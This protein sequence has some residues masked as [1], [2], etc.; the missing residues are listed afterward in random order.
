MLSEE[1]IDLVDQIQ[2]KKCELQNIELKKAEKGTPERLYDTLSSFSNQTGGG[3][4]IFGLSEKD[5]YAVTGVYN[6][7]DIQVKVTNQALQMTPVIRPIFTVAQINGKNV[8]SAEISECEIYD[9]PCFYTGAG[10]IRG[11]YVRVGEA[12]LPMTEYEIYSYE[13][14]KRRIQDELRTIERSRYENFDQNALAEYLLKIR[15]EKPNLSKMSTERIL[16]LQGI[17]E[18]DRL[19]VAGIML[20]TEYPQ[21]FFPQL[22]IT[23]MVVS[24]T[25]FL[26]IGTKEERFIDNKRIEGRLSQ[27][28]TEAMNFVRRNSRNS[29][30]IDKNGIRKDRQEYPMRAVREIILNALIHRDYSI[31]TEN[32]P[33]RLIM[34]DDR[35]EIENP[36]GLYGRITID[37][38]GKAAADTRNP[39]IA[40]ALEILHDTENRFTGIPTIIHEMENAEMAPPVFENRRGTF[41]VIL[42]NQIQSNRSSDLDE[43]PPSISSNIVSKPTIQEA[44][45]QYCSIP[46]SKLQ[47]AEYLDISSQYYV[48]NHYIKP[49]LLENKLTMTIPDKPKSKKQQYVRVI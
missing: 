21:A 47:I 16:E 15:E 29:I 3:I 9:K 11:S 26:E 44:I 41:K 23:A 5:D 19:T 20:L 8:V 34:F 46:R 25:E 13:V 6:P 14:F 38:L 27:M 45:L 22:S 28:L 17:M 36:G 4:I 31:H 10:R 7:Q 1:L 32:S 40:G 37:E 24:G 39:F 35:I 33:I 43:S 49:L 48:M 42:Y 30:S 12:D 18:S 2:K